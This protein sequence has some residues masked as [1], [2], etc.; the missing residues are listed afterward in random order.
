MKPLSNIH[1]S[2]NTY[3]IKLYFVGYNKF[4]KALIRV[5]LFYNGDYSRNISRKIFRKMHIKYAVLQSNAN[6]VI[7]DIDNVA[8]LILSIKNYLEG[9]IK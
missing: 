1:I 9:N 6:Y 8:H 4:G 7:T 2:N 3:T 5:Y